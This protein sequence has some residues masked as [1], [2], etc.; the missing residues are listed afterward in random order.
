MNHSD[1]SD[2]VAAY[3]QK[4]RPLENADL[5]AW[6]VFG[7]HHQPRPEDFPVQLQVDALRLLRCQSLPRPAGR[8]KQGELSRSGGGVG[9][10]AGTGVPRDRGH[11]FALPGDLGR[12]I[13][14]RPR[15][16]P[17]R[18]DVPLVGRYSGDYGC[19]MVPGRTSAYCQKADGP[20]W[21]GHRRVMIRNG[22]R[23]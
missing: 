8:R 1:G 7:L 18:W 15:G 2:G 5:V 10:K 13:S 19:S 23:Q 20:G 9:E 6:H 4:D 22:R 14:A 3:V 17:D 12:R 11:A 16:Q 21:G